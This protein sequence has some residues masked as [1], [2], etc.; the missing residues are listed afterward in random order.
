VASQPVLVVEHEAHCPPGWVGEWLADAGE[1]LDVRRPYAG[2]PLPEGLAGHGGMV[3]LGGSMDAY[4]DATCPWLPRTR[5]LVRQAAA[6]GTPTLGICLGHQLVAVA[7][8]GEVCRNPAGQQIGIFD[9]GWLPEA[10]DDALS[11]ALGESRIAVQWNSDIVTRMPERAVVLAK[12][13]DGV[14]QAA[15]FADTVWGVQWHPEVDEQTVKAWADDERDAASELGVD[16]DARV[17]EMAAATDR[18]RR[19]WQPLAQR[20]AELVARLRAGST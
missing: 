15:R 20:F 12:T 16:V 18:L 4:S 17:A 19:A 14:V 9:V 3:V 5:E 6:A 8:G 2:D 11:G 10:R 7:L 13:P 1:D